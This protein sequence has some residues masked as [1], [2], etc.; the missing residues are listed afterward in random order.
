M[1]TH[2][3]FQPDYS[4]SSPY[5]RMLYRSLPD[6][7]IAPQPVG[8]RALLELPARSVSGERSVL[9]LHWTN[10]VVQRHD[11]PLDAR[12]SMRAFLR[13]VD[14]LRSEGAVLLW[15]LHNVLPHDYRHHVL[16]LELHR[17]LAERA[18]IVHTLTPRTVELAQP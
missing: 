9:H 3:Y 11:D 16:E 2:L 7:N 4:A 10:P 17:S 13:E 6:H 15:T 14:R 12:R 1:I 18:D 5:Q 8:M